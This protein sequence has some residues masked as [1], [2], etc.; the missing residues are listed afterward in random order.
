MILAPDVAAAATLLAF[1]LLCAGGY[2][3]AV[4]LLGEER[5]RRDPLALAVG[6]LVGATAQALVIGW[7]LGR[8]GALRIG[9]ALPIQ[10]LLVGLLLRARRRAGAGPS[11]VAGAGTAKTGG[12]GT[13]SAASIVAEASAEGRDAAGS[14][15]AET[16]TA[17]TR[18]AGP[19]RALAERT[20]ARLR[21]HPLLAPLAVPAVG[22]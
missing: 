12:V 10:A 11:G 18:V 9:L 8:A 14:R 17:E 5:C 2:L 16:S 6:L 21:G 20:A 3:M 7:A 22:A 4:A 15:A 13:A 1:A 19:A